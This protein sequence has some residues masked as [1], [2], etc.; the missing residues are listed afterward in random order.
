MTEKEGKNNPFT[1][2][3]YN[4]LEG[5]MEATSKSYYG[6]AIRI[7]MFLLHRILSKNASN[8]TYYDSINSNRGK[9]RKKLI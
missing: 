1:Q 9:K 6:D 7:T 3:F 2:L 5:Y 4:V 8:S